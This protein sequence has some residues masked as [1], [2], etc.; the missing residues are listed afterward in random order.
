[1][2]LQDPSAQIESQNWVERPNAIAIDVAT[3]GGST[4]TAL[5]ETGW[6]GVLGLL[7]SVFKFLSVLAAIALMTT[8]WSFRKT[9]RRSMMA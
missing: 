6:V 1:M 7:G 5:W 9:V 8:W 3:P 4:S 2:I